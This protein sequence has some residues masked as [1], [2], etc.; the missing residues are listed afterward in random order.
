[1]RGTGK[2][3]SEAHDL[4]SRFTTQ[5]MASSETGP[6]NDDTR[7]ADVARGGLFMTLA[8]ECRLERSTPKLY[9][10]LMAFSTYSPTGH[11]LF[12]LARRRNFLFNEKKDL[13]AGGVYRSANGGL[14]NTVETDRDNSIGQN[15][16]VLPHEIQH[17]VQAATGADRMFT[18]WNGRS[19]MKQK[20]GMEAGAVVAQIR[21][22]YE[23]K[24]C[25]NPDAWDS[26]LNTTNTDGDTDRVLQSYAALAKGFEARYIDAWKDGAEHEDAMAK[27]GS[28]THQN[29]F[30]TAML[31]DIYGTIALRDY[32][33]AVMKDAF[34][35]QPA[36]TQFDEDHARLQCKLP[37]GSD[38]VG[39]ARLPRTDDELFGA[40]KK[41]RQAYD[42]V[43]LVRIKKS[44]E[45]D[46]DGYREAL[47]EA[48]RDRNPYLAI[49]FRE[50]MRKLAEDGNGTDLLK[51][52]DELAE[53]GDKAKLEMKPP[54][55]A[56]K[57]RPK[58]QPKG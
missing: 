49:D 3:Q 41:L 55:F 34:A 40:N 35:D 45:T 15:M 17:G 36:T 1:M 37:D 51:V 23:M 18:S 31:R 14:R 12:D 52:M 39:E 19:F 5:H 2:L 22:A 24:M 47:A 8:E 50:V 7:D 16:A 57:P 20:L 30:G 48:K 11:K 29:Y 43:E 4:K 33:K 44:N 46:M 6:A 54:K 27:A 21:V 38:M 26:L 42:A 56:V 28:R 13:G 10:A 9:H 25:G 53:A 58:P 32:L